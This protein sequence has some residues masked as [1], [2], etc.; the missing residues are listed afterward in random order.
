M[1]LLDKIFDKCCKKKFV[2]IDFKNFCTEKERIRKTAIKI[3]K[4][5]SKHEEKLFYSASLRDHQ[6]EILDFSEDL[7]DKFL[8]QSGNESYAITMAQLMRYHKVYCLYYMY[9]E[10]GQ[11]DKQRQQIYDCLFQV[12]DLLVFNLLK[13]MV[14]IKGKKFIWTGNEFFSLEP[15]TEQEAGTV[16]TVCELLDVNGRLI[17]AIKVS[18][19]LKVFSVFNSLTF[20][21]INKDLTLSPFQL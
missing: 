8:E 18:N 1:S 15:L 21:N 6:E 7:K 4:I 9:A 5:V 10:D 19:N 3:A 17:E 16:K 2:S 12:R 11:T 14:F 20:E 13:H